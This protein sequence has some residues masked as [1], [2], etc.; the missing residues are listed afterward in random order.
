MFYR[1]W[2]YSLALGSLAATAAWAD[3]PPAITRVCAS[4]HGSAGISASPTYPN[5]AGQKE[6][7]LAYALRQYKDHQRLGAQAAMMSGIAAPLSPADISAVAA[8]YASLKAP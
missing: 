1:A 7:Y 4:C 6:G 3:S 8:Y 5:L 2:I